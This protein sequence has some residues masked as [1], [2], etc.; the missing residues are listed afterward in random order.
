MFIPEKGLKGIYMYLPISRCTDFVWP[1]L[2]SVQP[3]SHREG[4]HQYFTTAPGV[5]FVRPKRNSNEHAHGPRQLHVMLRT[6]A[7]YFRNDSAVRPGC[8]I[9]FSQLPDPYDPS[10]NIKRSICRALSTFSHSE[11][12][13]GD[14]ESRLFH[15]RRGIENR[16]CK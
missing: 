15:A 11:N 9:S 8:L 7:C 2:H 12:K 1:H 3:R 10:Q 14:S 13:Q 5:A 4:P 16:R 6:L